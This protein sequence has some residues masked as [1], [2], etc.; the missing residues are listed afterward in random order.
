MTW[1]DINGDAMTKDEDEKGGTGLPPTDTLG[2]AAVDPRLL[3]IARAIG[4]L[5]A[6]EQFA[7]QEVARAKTGNLW[8]FTEAEARLEEVVEKAQS[9]GPQRITHKGVPVAV[10][11]SA[12]E[13]QSKAMRSGSL[14]DF[15]AASP[16]RESRLEIDRR[17]GDP[18]P[19]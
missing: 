18:T 6:R 10:I 13:R 17:S 3:T 1:A 19:D 14:A 2:D 15:F 5:I 12:E 11:V 4:R 7:A 8:T 9:D 16:L